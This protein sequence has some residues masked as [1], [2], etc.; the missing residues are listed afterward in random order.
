[1]AQFTIFAPAEGR[2][3]GMESY[4]GAQGCSDKSDRHGR[5]YQKPVDIG[6]SD[7]VMQKC[8][9]KG[10]ENIKSITI[11]RISTVCSSG[12]TPVTKGVEVDLFCRNNCNGF[13]GT[14][15]Y[16]HLHDREKNSCLNI[17]AE[18][19]IVYL[20]EMHDL[21]DWKCGCNPGCCSCGG[22][23]HV[24]MEANPASADPPT[25]SKA[26][27]HSHVA[28]C[29]DLTKSVSG[30]YVFTNDVLENCNDPGPTVLRPEVVRV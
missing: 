26:E 20:G 29:A 15:R 23:V 28:C 25:K 9:F 18:N 24:H 27:Y 4:C 12:K 30:V 2:V 7:N 13:I 10:S 19:R 21:D 16:G 1:M 11:R 6:R 22:G 8:Y 5:H 14:L 17:T 3:W